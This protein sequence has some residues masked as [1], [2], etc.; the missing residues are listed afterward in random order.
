[1]NKSIIVEQMFNSIIDYTSQLCYFYC[2]KKDIFALFEE[3]QAAEPREPEP[4]R[5]PGEE[6]AQ[7]EPETEQAPKPEPEPR[8][9][10][11]DPE[12][13]TEKE[14]DQNVQ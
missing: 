2:M 10:E 4:E 8:E 13:E 11:K 5:M 3:Q 14:G 1:M 12:K 7:E 9:P 6:P